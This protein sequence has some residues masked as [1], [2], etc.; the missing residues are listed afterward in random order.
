MQLLL[1]HTT[2][3]SVAR[4]APLCYGVLLLAF[5]FIIECDCL[6]LKGVF[7]PRWVNEGDQVKIE[8]RYDLGRDV[9]YSIKWY[10]DS[11][12]IYRY[13]PTDQPEYKSFPSKGIKV[14]EAKTRPNQ[15]VIRVTGPLGSGNYGCEV[16]IETPS[17]VTLDKSTNITVVVPPKQ[18]PQI[19]GMA[20]FYMP[21]DLVEI[22]CSSV[23]SKPAPDISWFINGK[24][25]GHGKHLPLESRLNR[26]T[27]L[28]N[29]WS[30]LRF[31]SETDYFPEGRMYLTCVAQIEDLWEGKT[32]EIV[33]GAGNISK[34]NHLL[35]SNAA[36]ATSISQ[37]QRSHT[38]YIVLGTL[39]MSC[40]L[41]HLLHI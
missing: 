18:P 25:A 4:M 29:S 21:G 1:W 39:S 15:L 22:N 16:T 9:V 7:G 11:Q 33:L 13:V 37:F 5:T 10:K 34:T 40:T 32:D 28:E 12:E 2:S 38:S 8:C 24:K 6:K 31:V 17:F 27:G 35:I 14:D 36:S 30:T 19:S 20:N 23:D 26:T 41:K 3:Q